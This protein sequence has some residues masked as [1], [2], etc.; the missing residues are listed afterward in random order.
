M[1]A[2]ADHG[3]RW[4]PTWFKFDGGSFGRKSSEAYW[5]PARSEKATIPQRYHE[6]HD[7]SAKHERRSLEE[8]ANPVNPRSPPNRRL[9]AEEAAAEGRRRA[10]TGPHSWP[11]TGTF[12]PERGLEEARSRRSRSGRGSAIATLLPA[13]SD[14]GEA[15]RRELVEKVH[16]IR[17]RAPGG[18]GRRPSGRL[19]RVR[20][21]GS[22]KCRPVT[23]PSTVS[24]TL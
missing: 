21:E 16:R 17:P 24:M 8:R 22:A 1:P 19:S 7:P 15:G 13:L 4:F 12:S 11:W 2:R 20:R 3:F 10:Q 5:G 14:P 18:A 9:R 23:R 6:S